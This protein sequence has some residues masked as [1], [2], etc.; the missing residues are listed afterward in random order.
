[1]C[2]VVEALNTSAFASLRVLYVLLPV[3]SV[4]SDE[5]K[6]SI[7]TLSYT[8]PDRLIEQTTALSATSRWNCSLL[9][10]LPRSE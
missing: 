7:A 9:C 4:F 2:R 8:L 10:S 3:R 5:K 6:L 1:M